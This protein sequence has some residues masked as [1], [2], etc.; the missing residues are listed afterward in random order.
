MRIITYKRIKEFSEKHNDAQ[1]ALRDWYFKTEKANWSTF[2][3][4]KRTFNHVDIVGNN[5]IIFNIKGNQYRLVAI[6]IFASKKVYIRFLGTHAD[7]D[8]IDCTSI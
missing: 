1:V 5:R 4:V 2:S 6:V 7:Y 8:K 3:D